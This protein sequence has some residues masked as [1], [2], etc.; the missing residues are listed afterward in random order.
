VMCAAR[1]EASAAG[2]ATKK[3]EST[4]AN[5]TLSAYP[6]DGLPTCRYPCGLAI[7]R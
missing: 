7:L 4:S 1:V 6:F 2:S 5:F 3:S